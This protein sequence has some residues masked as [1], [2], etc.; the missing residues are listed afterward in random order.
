MKKFA[1]YDT[2]GMILRHGQCQGELVEAQAGEGELVLELESEIPPD[3]DVTH[4]VLEGEVTPRPTFGLADEVT[5]L[6]GSSQDFTIPDPCM[7]TFDGE[8]HVVTG[9]VLSID[10]E[11]PAAY[12]FG[13]EQWPYV[14]QTL[15]VTVYAL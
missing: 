8:E 3:L 15:K 2:T 14:P 13:F 12:E 1:V 7:V 9:G 4:Y 5:I 11:M 6:V 10:C